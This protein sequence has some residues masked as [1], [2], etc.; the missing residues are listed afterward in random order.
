MDGDTGADRHHVGDAARGQA[1]PESGVLSLTG[2]GHHDR[3]L[4]SPGHRLVQQVQGQP[5]LLPVADIWQPVVDPW[6][7]DR[8]ILKQPRS[9][10]KAT[11]KQLRGDAADC[12]ISQ[13][14]EH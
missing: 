8:L 1:G 11:P 7:A 14:P 9:K 10:S 2:I 12:N 6:T 13:L 4:E 3:R 5:P